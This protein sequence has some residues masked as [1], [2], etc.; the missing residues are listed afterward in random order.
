MTC[1]LGNRQR[2]RIYVEDPDFL[3]KVRPVCDKDVAKCD[4][5]ICAPP[6]PVTITKIA[7][8]FGFK[9]NKTISN[10]HSDFSHLD[11]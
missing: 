11:L 4:M 6:A 3:S 1:G 7:D 2:V 5:G 8:D 10:L 9:V